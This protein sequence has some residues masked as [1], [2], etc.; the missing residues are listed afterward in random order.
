MKKVCSRCV[1]SLHNP[2]K[3]LEIVKHVLGCL[4]SKDEGWLEHIESLAEGFDIEINDA[5]AGIC[6]LIDGE[7]DVR[8]A[9]RL[10][11]K[12][13]KSKPTR[14][15]AAGYVKRLTIQGVPERKAIEMVVKEYQ[16]KKKFGVSKDSVSENQVKNEYDLTCRHCSNFDGENKSIQES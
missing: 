16:L 1:S 8:K 5:Y 13:S 11:R 3:E 14:R 2:Y 12:Q 7:N 15:E 10:G 9:F 4:I 6:R